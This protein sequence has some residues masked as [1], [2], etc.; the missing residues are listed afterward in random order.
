MPNF[1]L[2]LAFVAIFFPFPNCFS[3][4]HTNFKYTLKKKIIINFPMG[5]EKWPFVAIYVFHVWFQVPDKT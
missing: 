5:I 4:F 2:C 1:A 3:T